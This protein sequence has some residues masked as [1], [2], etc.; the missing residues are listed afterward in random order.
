[1]VDSQNSS[2][3]PNAPVKG[4][5]AQPRGRKVYVL[6]YISFVLFFGTLI[7][8]G[9][10]FFL[11]F[12]QDKNL[13]LQQQR[14]DQE[15]AQFSESN[16]QSVRELSIQLE[17]AEQ[18]LGR[19]VSLASIL[20]SLEY[21]LLKSVNIVDFAFKKEGGSEY[22]LELIAEAP[23]FNS[24]LFQREILSGNA[25]LSGATISEVQYGTVTTEDA[26]S[27]TT[28]VTDS[29]L[30]KISKVLTVNDIPH[31]VAPPVALSGSAEGGEEAAASDV[32]IPESDEAT[33]IENETTAVEPVVFDSATETEV[34]NE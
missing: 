16:L 33:I 30:F 23:Q 2:F 24:A 32:L 12:Q 13:Q 15:K 25:I 28:Q 20:T 6:S 29:L 26:D 21:T 18:L 22:L 34:V 19:H 9:I 11:G 3:I 14:L 7:V 17:A 8:T 10:V 27:A 31:T 5:V 1:M 4:E